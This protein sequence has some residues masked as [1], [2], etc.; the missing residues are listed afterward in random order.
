VY[1]RVEAA[2]AAAAA[3]VVVALAVI[4][5]TVLAARLLKIR[6]QKIYTFYYIRFSG[7]KIWQQSPR[8]YVVLSR[9]S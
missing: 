7:R 1:N 2:A 8:V 4:N 6:H 3:V 9:T 5:D